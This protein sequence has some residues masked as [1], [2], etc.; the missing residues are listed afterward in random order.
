[1]KNFKKNQE[2]LLSKPEQCTILSELIQMSKK[3]NYFT[4][5]IKLKMMSR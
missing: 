4:F 1:M 5:L 3:V 2:L